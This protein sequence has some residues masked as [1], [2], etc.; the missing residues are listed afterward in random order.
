MTL[1]WPGAGG[2]GVTGGGWAHML[3]RGEIRLR[4]QKD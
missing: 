4:R 2:R 1:A 3:G